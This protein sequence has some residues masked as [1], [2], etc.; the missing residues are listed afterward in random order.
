MGK[1]L[2]RRARNREYDSKRREEKPYRNWYK[3]RRWQVIR[4]VQL[5]KQPLCER[6]LAKMPQFITPA[7]VCHHTIKHDGDP[8]IFWGGPFASSC[9]DCHD[10]DGPVEY[11]LREVAMTGTKLSGRVMVRNLQNARFPRRNKNY[12]YRDYPSLLP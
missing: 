4:D 7:T 10:V 8:I 3:L 12:S 11:L 2:D 6:C 5:A 9:K 1:P